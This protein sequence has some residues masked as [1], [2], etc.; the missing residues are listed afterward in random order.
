M[1]KCFCLLLALILV[2]PLSAAASATSFEVQTGTGIVS[3]AADFE[4]ATDNKK[5]IEAGA[6]GKIYAL[7][8]SWK[9][10]GR[11]VYNAGKTVYAWNQ[12]KLKYDSTVTNKGWTTTGANVV[13]T[14]VNRGNRDVRITCGSPVAVSGLTIT[15]AY[16]RSAFTVPSAATNGF[17]EVG[18][19]QT[20][21]A[22][23]SISK[24]SGDSWNGTGNIGNITVTI[25]GQ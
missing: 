6:E 15:G 9:Q 25:A 16:D 12:G 8:L 23:Y 5:A 14:A 17:D 20:G 7:T 3:I 10:N 22:T 21:S 19:E 18:A 24:V 4:E 1:K 11:I 13:I 2:M